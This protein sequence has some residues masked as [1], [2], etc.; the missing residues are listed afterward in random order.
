MVP[1][2]Q[3][4]QQQHLVTWN[5]NSQATS[6]LMNQQLVGEAHGSQPPVCFNEPSVSFLST[7]KIESPRS[8][9]FMYTQCTFPS[10][11]P[12]VGPGTTNSR[13]WISGLG[14]RVGLVVPLGKKR[15]HR[16][17]PAL[18]LLMSP[19]LLLPLMPLTPL[20]VWAPGDLPEVPALGSDAL[21]H[22]P[23]D[24][25]AVVEHILLSL[26]L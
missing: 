22:T 16:R 23:E 6:D 2:Q 19:A 11:G 18:T 12:S 8:K 5:T 17:A 1:D 3:Q 10:Q 13:D 14:L 7:L 15:T 25:P 26:F 4:Q 24:N 9:L 20:L 21:L